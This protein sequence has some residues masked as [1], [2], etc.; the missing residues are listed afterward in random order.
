L[1]G[2]VTPSYI[3]IYFG[4]IPLSVG[5]VIGII[6]GFVFGRA[7]GAEQDSFASR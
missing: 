7:T 6:I 1:Y 2:P 3:A 5:L 4:I